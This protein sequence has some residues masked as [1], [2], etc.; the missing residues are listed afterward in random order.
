LDQTELNLPVDINGL[1]AD[2]CGADVCGVTSN[3][4]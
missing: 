2:S 4:D 3:G 1:P